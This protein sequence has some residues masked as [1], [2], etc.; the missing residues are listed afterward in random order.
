MRMQQHGPTA[1]VAALLCGL[2]A[3]PGGAGCSFGPRALERS[4]GPYNESVRRVEEEQLLRNIVHLRYNESPVHLNI[5]SI[6]TQYELTAQAEARPFFIAP[7]PRNSN[8]VFRTF[9][10]ILPDVLVGGANRPTVTLDPADDSNATRQFLTPITPETLVFLQQTSW[11]VS[12]VTRLW[13]DR[14]NGVPNAV[15]ASGP[16]RCIPPDFARFLRAAELLQEAQD[17]ELASVRAEERAAEVGDPLPPDAVTAAAQVEAAK[18]GL[19]YVR[20]PDGKS[21]V[22]VRRERRLVVEVSPGAEASPQMAELAGL[23][24]LLPG[25][26]RYEIVAASRGSPDPARF[27]VPPSDRLQVVVRSTAQVLFYLTNG[28]EVPPEHLAEGLVHPPV[29]EGGRLLDGREITRGLFEVHVCGGHK[30]PATAFVAVRYRGFWYYIDDRDAASKATLALVLQ[31]SRLDF[32]RE[33]LG[34]RRGP[35]LTLPAG[36]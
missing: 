27:P 36:R 22:L 17:R 12:T 21:W 18:A 23:L 6:A 10:A 20:R 5:T 30:P 14:I 26:P 2:A 3:G 29:D 25:L 35:L 33:P 11:P 19:E 34:A 4:H 15:T 16:A 7:N 24:D 13:V 9:T 28:V 1:L 31:V 32:S 8:I